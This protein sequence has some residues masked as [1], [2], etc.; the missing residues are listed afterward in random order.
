MGGI[1]AVTIAITVTVSIGISCPSI[2]ADMVMTGRVRLPL[3]IQ[4]AARGRLRPP[5]AFLPVTGE[6]CANETKPGGRG[7]TIRAAAL[8]P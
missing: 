1:I 8:R 4:A 5:S 6:V 2:D 7:C 3:P